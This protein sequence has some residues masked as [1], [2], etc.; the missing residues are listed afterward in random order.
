MTVASKTAQFGSVVA[1]PSDS[2][3]EG[4][5]VGFWETNMGYNAGLSLTM[6]AHNITLYAVW[7]CTHLKTPEDFS[8]FTRVVNSGADTFEGTTVL[9]DSDLSL[10]GKTLEPIGTKTHY[11]LGTFDGQRYVIS[12]LK[13]TSS[14]KHVGLFGYSKGLTVRNVILD[15]SCSVTI[16]YKTSINAYI[17]GVIGRC[18]ASSG[19]CTIE[20]SANMGSVSFTGEN[21]NNIC[22]SEGLRDSLLIP[23]TIL[24]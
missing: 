1:L 23:T 24:L 13:M 12:N 15:S 19:P 6:P 8:D 18:Y 4:C 3:R 14:S 17:G 9:L 21:S 20:N 11:F 5:S 2:I 10:A 16:S 22:I 7:K